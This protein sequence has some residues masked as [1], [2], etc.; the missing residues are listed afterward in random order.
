MLERI[1][2]TSAIR[3]LLSARTLA[4]AI[5]LCAALT[6]SLSVQQELPLD[7]RLNEHVVQIPAGPGHMSML[8]TTVFKPNGPGPF[9]LLIINHGKDLGRPSDQPRDRFIHMAT[10]F[11]KRGYAVIVPMR[12]GFAASTGRY[13]DHGC[14]M[15]N[16]GYAQ[17]ENIRDAV[18]Y[19]RAQPWVD[20]DRIIIAGQSYGGL[21]TIA[22][23]THALPG[24]RGLI[25]FAGG[26]AD[27]DKRCD[28]RSSL[29]EAF[30]NYGRKNILPTLWMYGVNDSLFDP[31]LVGR[32]HNAFVGAGGRARLVQYGAFK[33]D[34]H[35][36]VSSRDGEKVWLPETERFLKQI[37]MPTEEVYAVTP[38]PA[39]PATNYASVDDVTA[40]PYLS[41]QGRVAYENYLSKQQPRAFAISPTGAWS[42]AEEGE[43][44]ETRALATCRQSSNAPCR[45]YSVDNAVVWQDDA[46]NAGAT[47]ATGSSGADTVS[48][49]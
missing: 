39:L 25:N 31:E 46:A 15:T 9:P 13:R 35:G 38:R 43:D 1:I 41:R 33:R 6:P 7:Y 24:V 27:T 22:L 23:G 21:A 40:V 18:H 26:L 37:G 30:G 45:L 42:W 44:P 10:A 34:A 29:V 4:S 17:A 28:W 47:A 32:M 14:D 11:V 12:E 2:D 3:S 16:N 49:L 48:S 36:M 19:A 20:E 5:A 8:E